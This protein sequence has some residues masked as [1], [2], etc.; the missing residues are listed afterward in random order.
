MIACTV[1]K[2]ILETMGVLDC[3]FTKYD[4]IDN[5]DDYDDDNN[6]NNNYNK[7]DHHQ[8]LSP[9]DNMFK[10]LAFPI[11]VVNYDLSTLLTMTNLTA[12]NNDSIYSFHCQLVRRVTNNMGL[13]LNPKYL[14]PYCKRQE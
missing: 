1:Y 14:C 3:F 13:E 11:I 8:T 5:D 10:T 7:N 2:N 4:D 12:K 9:H 6:D